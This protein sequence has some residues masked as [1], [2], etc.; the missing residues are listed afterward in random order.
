MKQI[1]FISLFILAGMSIQSVAAESAPRERHISVQGHGKVS[2][3]PDQARL[4]VM[5]TE[6]GKTVDVVTQEVRKKMEAVLQAI[7]AQG[8]ADKDIQTQWYRVSPK[9][10]WRNNRSVRTGYTASNQVQVTIHDLK[11]TGLVLDAVQDAGANDV[12]GPEFG[13]ENPQALDHKALA[14]ALQ[15]A[16]AKAA[17]LAQTAGASLGE[18]L[19]IDEGTA[20]RPG[21]RPMMAM[22]AALAAA[23]APE[24][25]IAAGE[26]TVE[27]TVSVSFALK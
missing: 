1:A 8:L 4:Q 24:E 26:E 9:M 12:N 27:A 20:Y 22:K 19:T 11:K 21:P 18:I 2:A 14:E 17:L 6:E 7:K 16:K 15:E 13:F 10:E 5:V 23:P 3:V 25:P